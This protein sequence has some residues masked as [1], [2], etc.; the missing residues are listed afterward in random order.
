M[1]IKNYALVAALACTA[2]LAG[3]SNEDTAKSTTPA[4]TTPAAT[5]EADKPADTTTAEPVTEAPATDAPSTVAPTEE[6]STDAPIAEFDLEASTFHAYI[7]LQTPLF[8][9]RN[10]VDDGSYGYNGTNN[11]DEIG[12]FVM[13]AWASKDNGGG[14][15]SA[16]GEF[17]D[18]NIT[19]DGTY[20]V[21]ATGLDWKVLDEAQ[22]GVEFEEG[23]QYNL[24]FV[25][26][27]IPWAAIDYDQDGSGVSI[28]VDELVIG[29]KTIAIDKDAINAQVLET[30]DGVA[31]ADE[32]VTGIQLQL[33][34]AWAKSIA[35]L[36]A[37]DGYA[38]SI[39]I[40]FTIKGMDNLGDDAKACI[41]YK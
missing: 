1:R 9:F 21:S 22:G 6:P 24:I 8:S 3:C 15:I 29:G 27:D 13:H 12:Y 16:P 30:Y 40:T 26:T 19:G 28:T 31:V 25:S 7:G 11:T 4:S 32:E 14:L 39:S 41:E 37:Y 10:A 33:Q 20:T 38:D 36:P 2:A 5:T 34:N 17:H 23:K 18:V 35:T